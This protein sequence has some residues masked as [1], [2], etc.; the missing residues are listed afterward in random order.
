MF[1]TTKAD[2]SSLDSRLSVIEGLQ[3]KY[4]EL[5]KKF[6]CLLNL[7]EQNF[8]SDVQLYF[9]LWGKEDNNE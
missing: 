8:P 9:E 1:S 6:N 3:C 2:V 7:V 5:E 4:D